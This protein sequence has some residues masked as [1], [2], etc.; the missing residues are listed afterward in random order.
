MPIWLAIDAHF[1]LSNKRFNVQR[2]AGLLIAMAGV[3]WI[4]AAHEAATEMRIWG[5]FW[6]LP[7]RLAGRAWR[8]ACD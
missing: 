5:V 7:V 6:L 1:L 2:S 4:L 3:I 8:Y